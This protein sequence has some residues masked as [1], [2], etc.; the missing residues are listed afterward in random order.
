MKV[1][2]GI[3]PPTGDISRWVYWRCWEFGVQTGFANYIAWLSSVRCMCSIGKLQGDIGRFFRHREKIWSTTLADPGKSI[4]L[5]N[6][7]DIILCWW[8]AG[9]EIA[10]QEFLETDVS[11]RREPIH[12]HGTFSFHRASRPI[13]IINIGSVL[14][15][16]LQRYIKEG[17][18]EIYLLKLRM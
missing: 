9:P 11:F 7:A 13:R 17:R 6:C 8:L 12:I 15:G 2:Y 10:R 5:L 3:A 14:Q 16:V 1:V 4:L 18:Y